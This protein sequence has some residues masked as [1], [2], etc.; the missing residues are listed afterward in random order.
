MFQ[1]RFEKLF[2]GEYSPQSLENT[3]IEF[4]EENKIPEKLRIIRREKNIGK[5]GYVEGPPTLNGRPHIGHTWGRAVKDLWY[6][7]KSMQGYYVL[8][9]AGWDCQGLPVEIEAE[10][11][12]GFSNKKEALAKL[13]EEKFIE[14]I[15]KILHKYHADWRRVDRRFGMF[16]DY[17]KEYFTYKDEY[18]EREWKY[19][20]RAYEQGLLGKGYRVVAYCPSCQT[21]LS[22]AEV[23]QEYSMVEDPSIYFKLR[24]ETGDYILVWTTM[25]FTIVTDELL[26]VNPDAEYAIVRVGDEKWIMVRDLVDSLMSK[27]NISDY[28]IEGSVLGIELE[29]KRYEY[30]LIEEVPHQKKLEEED[31]RVH[32]I[33][34]A[35]FVDV[36]TGTGVVHIAP[37]NGEE[38]FE[39][40]QMLKIPVFSPFDDEARFTEEA[41]FF[42][43]V[44]AR[45]ADQ[46]VVELLEKKGLLLKFEKII[47][48]YPLCWRSKHR[49]IWLARTEYFYWLDEIVDKLV[50]AA[51]KVEYFYNPPKNRFLS[52]IKEGKPWCISRERVWGTPMP[53]F[54]CEK[55]GKEELLASR[56]EIVERALSLP[57]GE[58]FELHK[59]WMDKIKVKCS[60]G[61]VMHRVP[62][63]LD[64]WHNSGAA[65]Y[66]SI[67]DEEFKE[68]VP[69]EFLVESIDQTRGWAF[70]LLVENVILTGKPE[71]PYKAFLFYGQVLDE[72]GNKMSKS[73]GNVIN[74]EDVITKYSADLCRFY[75]LWKTNPIENINFSFNEMME[76]PYQVLNTFFNLG[77]LLKQNAEYD[78]FNFD[79]YS[80]QWA[81]RSEGVK[82][83]EKWVLSCLQKL[84]NTVTEGFNTMRIHESARAM[85]KFI[86]EV[87]SR[88]YV[89]MVRKDLW[90]DDPAEINRRMTIY[91]VLFHSLST[92]SRLMNPMTPFLAEAFYQGVVKKFDKKT[93]ESVNFEEWP[94]PDENLI[95]NELERDF[96]RIN[97]VISLGNWAR[98]KAGVKRRWPLKRIVLI[99]RDEYSESVSK[100]LEILRELLNVK[101]VVLGKSLE[102]AGV[103]TIVK[104]NYSTAGPKFKDKA[105][106]IAL[107]VESRTAEVVKI[108]NEKG[109]FLLNVDGENFE[110]LRE[111][112][113]FEYELPENHVMVSDKP[114]FA[115][116][117]TRRT[118]EL[119]AEGY[120]RDVARRIQAY[121]KELGLNPTDILSNVTVYGVTEEGYVR[122]KP[123]LK[124][125]ASLV[126]ANI[127]EVETKVPAER[128]GLK[129]YDIEGEKIYVKIVK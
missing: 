124:E 98:M 7:W 37:A 68:F 58:N 90:S 57:D 77:K 35:A 29:G 100:R 18:I 34:T 116:L 60:C 123:L 69:V 103:R 8:F 36:T 127:V 5:L 88:Q 114:G 96:E 83:P 82:D 2:D 70:T 6:R 129:E 95:N 59:P 38:D 50:E 22:N 3:V 72:K 76:R 128:E 66:S 78:G 48:E 10:K 105:G 86:I 122:L 32:R 115:V 111:D 67:T 126:R 71:A 63:V 43:G 4:W 40:A 56:R 41:G 118:P 120:M 39:L 62:F 12:L 101:E 13:G 30:P 110:L 97:E 15:K 31:S 113:V 47:H 79:K 53:I 119:I 54:V 125:L 85:E 33:V 92:V 91:A 102:D 45:D 44:F 27:L 14:E 25:P 11:E 16:M 55:C 106:K 104:L 94:K 117:D 64:T 23:G 81:L 107:H 75:L 109:K 24:L 1:D 49:L 121:R 9:R 51:S 99:L 28:V 65:P 46:I 17:D 52:F 80:L 20:K 42:K 26:A 19:L 73:L 74:T 84:V 112:L 89:P 87:L 108:L 93:L 21:S 61:G